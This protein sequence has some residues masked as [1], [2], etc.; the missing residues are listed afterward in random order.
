MPRIRLERLSFAFSDAVPIL[1]DVD[2]A[3]E[4]GF[5]GLV[6]ENG[7]GKSTFL[8]LVAGALAPTEGRVRV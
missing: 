4:E 3:L 8:A 7:A 6:G 5:T 1:A 2:L